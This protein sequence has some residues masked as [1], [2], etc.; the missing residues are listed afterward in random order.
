MAGKT[1]FLYKAV[2]P[3]HVDNAVNTETQRRCGAA[4]VPQDRSCRQGGLVLWALCGVA[5]MA[6]YFLGE[7]RT[8]VPLSAL[9][10]TG[11]CGWHHSRHDGGRSSDAHWQAHST[12]STG[13]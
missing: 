12:L 1:S 9:F 13:C 4:A 8:R 10:F 6:L 3:S 5:P 7:A 2:A 11:C